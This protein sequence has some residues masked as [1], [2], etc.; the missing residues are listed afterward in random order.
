M[1]RWLLVLALSVVSATASGQ[2]DERLATA[3]VTETASEISR[4]AAGQFQALTVRRS[5]L[6]KRYQDEL[7]AIDRLKNQRV[8]WRRDRELRHRLS[9]SLE[10][11][12]QLSTATRELERAKQ[13]L[14]RAR[15]GY[16]LAI[17]AELASG[18]TSG[19]VVQLKRIRS[20]LA[21]QVKDAPRHIVIPDLEIDPLADPEELDQRAAELRESEDELHRQLA[22]LRAQVAELDRRV[23]LRKQHERAGD[24]VNRD[25]DQPQRSAPTRASEPP[26][27]EVGG[28][29]SH[30][31]VP[32]PTVTPVE[33]APIV[34]A[35]LIDASTS[36]Q[37]SRDPAQRADA[38]RKAQDSVVRRL[39]QVRKRR[40][41]I[42][43]RART[44]RSR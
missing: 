31:Q 40:T 34:L 20:M 8:S 37:R 42:E 25:D 44:L 5:D 36:L 15:R 18:S 33:Y 10:T 39:E 43:T 9:S 29:G 38:A 4:A 30:P 27:D 13:R 32:P 12:N 22:V 24:L 19:R 6:A 28:V 26:E 35:E 14:E 2:P 7:D 21:P 3:G 17:D 23:L 1:S 41:E 11:A 16:L